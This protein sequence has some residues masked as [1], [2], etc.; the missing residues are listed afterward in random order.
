M[1]KIETFEVEAVR[2]PLLGYEMSSHVPVDG[3]S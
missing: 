2:M 1:V 3:Q